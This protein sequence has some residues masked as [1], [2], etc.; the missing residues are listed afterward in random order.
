MTFESI[1]E[2]SNQI[3]ITMQSSTHFLLVFPDHKASGNVIMVLY[4]STS[5]NDLVYGN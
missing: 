3:H 5:T 1:P 4:V 2:D